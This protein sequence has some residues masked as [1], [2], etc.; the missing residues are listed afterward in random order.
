M[1][2]LS[3]VGALLLAVAVVSVSFTALRAAA[4]GTGVVTIE[5]L[6][7]VPV[8]AP[9]K[10][11]A[12]GRSLDSPLY[13]L[14]Q[15]GEVVAF[16]TAGRQPRLVGFPSP[17]GRAM[18]V[19]GQ[20]T[21]YVATNAEAFAFSP[22]GVNSR[23]YKVAGQD[24]LDILPDGTLVFAMTTGP[25]AV[26]MVRHDGTPA[27]G[28]GTPLS[29]DPDPR[30]RRAMREALVVASGDGRI[31][32]IP[33]NIPWPVVRQY[34][35]TGELLREFPIQGKAID[36]QSR[37]TEKMLESHSVAAGYVIVTG[38]AID[39][40]TNHL[41][42]SMNGSSESALVYE[43]TPD[44]RKVSEHRFT[45]KAGPV[46]GVQAI[47]VRGPDMAVYVQG[48]G[49]YTLRRP[50]GHLAARL[51][52]QLMALAAIPAASA[53]EPCP[54]AVTASSCETSCASGG[55]IDCKQRLLD[56]MNTGPEHRI[57]A[58]SCGTGSTQCGQGGA[59]YCG[60]C[61]AASATSCEV[62]TG[63]Q[64]THNLAQQACSPSDPS[65]C[66]NMPAYEECIASAGSWLPDFC[67]CDPYSPILIGWSASAFKLT[68][69][70]HGVRFDLNADGHRELVA[71]TV[72]GG[73]TAFLALDRNHDGQI[74]DGRELF[75]NVTEQP[76][77]DVPNG[78]EALAVFDD[79]NA[80]GNGDGF[81]TPDDSV[82][83]ALRLWVDRNH[84]G[85]TQADELLTLLQGG[86]TR[87]SLHY[88]ESR[89]MDEFGNLFRYRAR[90]SGEP[91][92]SRWAWDVLL[93]AVR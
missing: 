43:Y 82:F 5:L 10:A 30:R 92:V 47:A 26:Q 61:G 50:P 89:R 77:T 11:L 7:P 74:T 81:I 33:R 3:I 13:G 18:A 52:H 46:S 31:Y 83:S 19:D 64:T 65:G 42:V 51:W 60:T 90:V 73:D 67:R 6:E 41:W 88:R 38:A 72:V 86:V 87:I 62:P 20:G 56:S 91:G 44:G 59:Q 36:I 70:A 40:D 84:D 16:D 14:L 53:E 80:G 17:Y 68:D 66:G 35:L 79:P 48:R 2:R 45:S 9:V 21:I 12:F 23:T 75:G 4:Q 32:L 63:A 54:P 37:P 27:G 29:A 15:S 25:V 58:W 28:F 78:F 93:R 39:S 85:A 1:R 8:E 55:S 71:W 49:V 22:S 34:D 57:V 69:A 24:S 76:P